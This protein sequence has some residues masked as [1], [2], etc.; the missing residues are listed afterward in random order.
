MSLIDRDGSPRGKRHFAFWNPPF[1]EGTTSDRRSSNT[2]ARWLLGKLIH[3]RV[4]TIAFVR[5]R[6][7]AE[8][9]YRYVQEDLSLVNQ[10]LGDAIRAYRGGYLPAERREIERQLFEGELLGVV[11]TNALEL[12][13]DIGDLDAALIVGYPGSISSMWQQR[14]V[15]GGS[16]KSR[17]WSLWH[18]TRP[19]INF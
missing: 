6:T 16:L 19:S 12:G 11:S 5:A 14:D 4:Q 10:R 18:T 15:Q 3:N 9:I 8:V 1:L 17:W 13:I 7:S 2:E